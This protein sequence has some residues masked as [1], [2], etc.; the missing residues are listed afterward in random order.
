MHEGNFEERI[1]Q[2]IA[3]ARSL[4]AIVLAVRLKVAE[5]RAQEAYE[6]I[7][8]NTGPAAAGSA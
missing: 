5:A 7:T 3:V 8:K 1:K 4:T 2:D 6:R